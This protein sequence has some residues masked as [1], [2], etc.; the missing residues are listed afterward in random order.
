MK[1]TTEEALHEEKM[2]QEEVKAR[3]SDLLNLEEELELLKDAAEMALD[4]N[5]SIEFYI[6][7]LNEQIDTK[8]SKLVEL[9]LQ[10]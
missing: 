8:K 10:W 1:S 9:E 3:S 2:L 4:E 6:D 5:H 7:K